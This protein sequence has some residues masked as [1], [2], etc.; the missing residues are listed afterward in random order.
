MPLVRIPTPL[1]PLCGGSPEVE[2]SATDVRGALAAI[3]ARHP[4]FGSRIL[5]A[6][7][8]IR[9][10]VSIFVAEEDVSGLDGLD[11]SLATDDVL[12]IVPPIAGGSSVKDLLTALRLTVP[13]T[14]PA[15]AAQ[16]LGTGP[17]G[18]APLLLD[19][20]EAD[21]WQTGHVPG[22][23]H[24][25]RGVLEMRI[26]GIEPDRSRRI[27]LYCAGGNRSLLA[28]ESLQRLGYANIA[29]V[30]G[31]FARW[32]DE[33]RPVK[34]PVV[35][36]PDDRR[37]YARHLSIPEVGEEGQARLLASKVVLVGAGGLGS[38]AAYYLAAAGVGT[39]TIVDDDVVDESN[40]QRQ[41]LHDTRSV[42]RPKVESARERLLALNPGITVHGL[43]E[44]LAPGNVE[45]V[46]A[47]HDVVLD[48]C[49]N[50]PTRYLVND[51]CVR[52]RI[53]N[54]HGSVYRFEGQATVFW[55]GKGPCYRCLYPEAPPPEL[56]PS[57]AEAGVLG[58]LPGLVGMLEAVETIK[59]L[60]GIGRTLT[61]RLLVI[62]ALEA[63]FTELKLRRDPA[64]RWCADGAPFPGYEGAE[65]S[66]AS[67]GGGAGSV[68]QPDRVI[69]VV[70]VPR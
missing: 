24:V 32:K 59:V 16:E 26:E 20:R 46:F 49:D 29:S 45:R 1:R 44:R 38:P 61:G 40:L 3:E 36:S 35:L 50:F 30:A 60:L 10:L 56:A 64:C 14:D 51:A 53:P 33:G 15:G 23:T 6:D 5:D 39:L 69:S 17:A 2:V 43:Q 4:G 27:L 52:L 28:A 41:I 37:R 70:G 34:A 63:S 68:A 9:E 22:A 57:C 13:E 47:G 8:Q 55:P 42:G 54:V 31:G 66:C 18:V 62:D 19:V 21:E 58:I 67:P 7:G 25:P 11:T 65:R 48:G 12:T